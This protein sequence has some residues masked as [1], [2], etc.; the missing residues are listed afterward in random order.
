MILSEITPIIDN[1]TAHS[2]Y[3]GDVCLTRGA[4]Y[5]AFYTPNSWGPDQVAVSCWPDDMNE[6]MKADCEVLPAVANGHGDSRS[7]IMTARAAGTP[8]ES[9]LPWETGRSGSFPTRSSLTFGGL[10]QRP[11]SAS[12]SACRDYITAYRSRYETVHVS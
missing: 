5:T 1:P 3:Y 9:M 6:D 11:T 4:G 8:P 7:Q 10:L 12:P 2:G